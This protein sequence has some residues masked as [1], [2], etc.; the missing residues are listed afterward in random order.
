MSASTNFDT[1]MRLGTLTPFIRFFFRIY[2]HT[3]IRR[4]DCTDSFRLCQGINKSPMGTEVPWNWNE[5]MQ[6]ACQ[7]L[8]T[9]GLCEHTYQV[10][11][12]MKFCLSSYGVDIIWPP[13]T[14]CDL[15]IFYHL[16]S[17]HIPSMRSIVV[18]PIKLCLIHNL[19][20]IDPIWPPHLPLIMMNIGL[21]INELINT[22]TKYEL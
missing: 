5:G 20:S 6:G 22:R 19:T 12:L 17:T 11:A 15:I 21:Y 18:S 13:M 1:S 3:Y 4:V 14:F 2:I 8:K 16:W 9:L 7:P 10:W